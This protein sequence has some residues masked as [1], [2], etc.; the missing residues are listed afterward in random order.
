MADIIHIPLAQGV[1][2]RLKDEVAKLQRFPEDCREG[3]IWQ[4]KPECGGYLVQHD[5]SPF[6]ENDVH[7][8]LGFTGHCLFGWSYN[9]IEPS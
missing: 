9:E 1:R 4:H 8:A 7:D 3:V 2:V 5:K 6:E